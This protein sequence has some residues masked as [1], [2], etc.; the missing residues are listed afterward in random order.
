MAGTPTQSDLGR[1]IR[2]IA[3]HLGDIAEA[4]ARPGLFALVETNALIQQDPSLA[5][6]LSD[7]SVLTAIEQ[8]FRADDVEEMLATTSWPPTV[9]GCVLV[10]PI[11]VLPPQAEQDLDSAFEP[12]LADPTA[13]DEA[14][15]TLATSHPEHQRARLHVGV[16]RGGVSVA[17][18][19]ITID[20]VREFRIHPSLAT[21]LIEA[22]FRTLD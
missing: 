21:N 4:N 3:D 12:L 1:A 17:L 11:V 2:D 18:L 6:Q 16:L 7:G 15:R 9:A 22:L 5:D 13:A 20:G 8:E 10:Q 19:E 14:A